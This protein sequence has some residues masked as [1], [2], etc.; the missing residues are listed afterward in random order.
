[1]DFDQRVW[2]AIHTMKNTY[3]YTP[4]VLIGMINTSNAVDA[5]KQLVNS[6]NPPKGYTHLWELHALH[7]SM[8]AIIQEDDWKGLFTEEERKKARKRLSDYGYKV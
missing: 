1:M 7:L 3:N 6:V 5:V 2:E 4:T 8:E